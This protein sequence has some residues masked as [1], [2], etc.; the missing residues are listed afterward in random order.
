[1]NPRTYRTDLMP[2][3]F[4]LTIRRAA[5]LISIATDMIHPNANEGCDNVNRS[6]ALTNDTIIINRYAISIK[7][8]KVFCFMLLY[9]LVC[10]LFTAAYILHI[11]YNHIYIP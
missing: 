8:L 6:T 11:I 5:M 2:G 3:T 10:F 4:L 7:L 1:M 9:S